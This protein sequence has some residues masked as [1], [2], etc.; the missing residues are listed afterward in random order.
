MSAKSRAR[1]A[2][3][4]ERQEAAQ[5][6]ALAVRCP[7]CRAAPGV[8]CG[9]VLSHAVF[10]TITPWMHERRYAITKES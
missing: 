5:R 9:P 6:A 7:A 10:H 8:W 3:R 1:R 4:H 2:R